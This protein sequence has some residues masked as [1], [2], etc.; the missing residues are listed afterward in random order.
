LGG[1]EGGQG[2]SVGPGLNS[3]SRRILF[4]ESLN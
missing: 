3:Y 1:G 2:L 4:D